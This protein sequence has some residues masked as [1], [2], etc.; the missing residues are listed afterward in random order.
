[1]KACTYPED[2]IRFVSMQFFYADAEV[3]FF[4]VLTSTIG[5]PLF[6]KS[7]LNVEY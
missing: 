6:Y 4:F 3:N 5:R 2:F 7:V 1:M